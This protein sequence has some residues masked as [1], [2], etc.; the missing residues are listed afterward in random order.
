MG[1]DF[2]IYSAKNHEVFKCDDWWNNPDV[3]EEFYARKCW[4]LVN[5][6]SFIPKDYENGDFMEIDYDMI[7]EMIAVACKYPNY[8]GN[9]DDVPK[10]CELR[11]RY[12]R[13]EAEGKKLYLE[14]DW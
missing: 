12:E 10:L 1:M 14:Y 8:F 11:D 13:I 7:E 3:Q 2:N 9:Y 4:D 5:N 6:C